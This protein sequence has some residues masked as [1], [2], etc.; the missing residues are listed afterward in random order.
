MVVGKA[1][2][3]QQ[4]FVCITI[5]RFH[6]TSS[7]STAGTVR[8]RLPDVSKLGSWQKLRTHAEDDIWAYVVPN[9]PQR[10]TNV[11][12][13][14]RPNVTWWKGAEIIRITDNSIISIAQTQDGNHGPATAFHAISNFERQSD[15]RLFLSKAK[16]F[17]AHTRMYHING[18][19]MFGFD[20]YFDWRKD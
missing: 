15:Y 1:D 20:W 9:S 11:Q 19:D 8:L 13:S 12:L 18:E 6:M 17:G 4:S 10:R 14:T 3:V 7:G 5:N 2:S 16:M